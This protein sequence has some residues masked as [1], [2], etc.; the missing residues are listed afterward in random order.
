M[1]E[2]THKE[3]KMNCV[4]F[5]LLNSEFRERE[6]DKQKGEVENYSMRCLST[7]FFFFFFGIIEFLAFKN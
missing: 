1:S 5:L 6:M 2:R 4:A 3:V 7:S